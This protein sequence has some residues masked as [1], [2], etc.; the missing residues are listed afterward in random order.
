M[1]TGV[2][3]KN[4]A[5]KTA[6]AVAQAR[7]IAAKK[8]MTVHANVS[9]DGIIPV[10]S[11][12]DLLTLRDAVI[13]LDEILAVA[14]SRESATL[15]AEV[16]LWLTTLRHSNNALLWTSPDYDRADVI[17]RGV[18]REA[19]QVIPFIATIPNRNSVWPITRFSWVVRRG[20]G[21]APGGFP[22]VSVFRLSPLFGTFG[23]TD[24]ANVLERR[25]FPTRCL[26]CGSSID[27]GRHKP[28]AHARTQS[29]ADPVDGVAH[30]HEHS[31][32]LE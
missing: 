6:W 7:K 4:G 11:F 23:S 30:E 24:D 10:R 5:G 29:G 19:V 15:P 13:I 17:L 27:Y 16:Q 20:G 18:T 32:H 2:V 31:A 21:L 9:G 1:I 8:G 3:G 26:D 25:R 22:S 12:D 14:G 28:D